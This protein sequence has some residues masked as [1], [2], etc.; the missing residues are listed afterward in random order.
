MANF[1]SAQKDEVGCAKAYNEVAQHF[2][3]DLKQAIV[4]LRKDLP[5]AAFTFVDVYSVK[6][7]LFK[8]PEKHGKSIYKHY[9][10]LKIL[11]VPRI[12]IL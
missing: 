4:Q 10:I 9:N 1:P 12:Q 7:S 8:E 5:L 6:Y 3:H 2:N 11:L